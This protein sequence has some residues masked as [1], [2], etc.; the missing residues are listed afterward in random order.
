MMGERGGDVREILT[1]LIGPWVAMSGERERPE[2]RRRR[3]R[4]SRAPRDRDLTHK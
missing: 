4:Q 1:P 2:K 3:R